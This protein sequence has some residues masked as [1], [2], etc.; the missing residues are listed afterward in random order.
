MTKKMIC[1]FAFAMLFSMT[2]VHAQ[3]VEAPTA[4]TFLSGGIG[5]EDRTRLEAMEKSFSLKLVLAGEGG[6]FLDDVHISITDA[7]KNS[8]LVT[9]TEGPILL[10]QLNPGKYIIT[11]QVQGL[12]QTQPVT[13]RKNRHSNITIRFPISE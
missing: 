2:S 4:P 11:A 5:D 10:V 1:A 12:T 3:T 13:I 9:D 7:A 6:M 8:V